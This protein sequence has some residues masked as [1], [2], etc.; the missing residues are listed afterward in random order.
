[1][2][3]LTTLE[4][5]CLLIRTVTGEDW[6]DGYVVTD[7]ATG[8]AEPGYGNDESVVVFG[9]WNPKRFLRGDDAPLT[10]SENVGPRLAEALENIGAEIEWLD[11]WTRC[12]ECYRAM[13]ISA[14]SYSW[15]LY[16]AFWDSGYVCADCLKKNLEAFIDD[17]GFI[18]NADKCLMPVLKDALT[19][20]GYVQWEEG[21]PHYYESGWHPGQDDKPADVL[22]SIKEH[23]DKLDVVFVLL[24]SGQ[25]DIRWAAFT[26]L[27]DEDNDTDE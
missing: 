19:G 7:V 8:Y 25:F 3:E 23:N 26:K 16:G 11:E 2:H 13:R 18:N 4:K 10:K 27:S 12:N 21:N 15:T 20:L 1:M 22:A 17:E 24:G 5:A 9:N 6:G 14:D